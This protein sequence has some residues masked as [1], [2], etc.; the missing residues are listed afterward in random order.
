MTT[1]DPVTQLH[2]ADQ[3]AQCTHSVA[4]DRVSSGAEAVFDQALTNGLTAIVAHSW[5]G[6]E[7]N[8]GG[9]ILSAAQLL[10]VVRDNSKTATGGVVRV[11]HDPMKPD[12]GPPILSTPTPNFTEV[13]IDV[14][15]DA[16]TTTQI[17]RHAREIGSTPPKSLTDAHLTALEALDYHP[18]LGVYMSEQ[19]DQDQ[20]RT[21]RADAAE[22]DR[23]LRTLHALDETELERRRAIDHT[24]QFTYRTKDS[25]RE[26]EEC[27]VCWADSL[28]VDHRDDLLD[29]IGIG[30]CY[31]CSYERTP[32][33]ADFMAIDLQI[34]RAM[35]KDD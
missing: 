16:I 10:D 14:L 7:K 2:R 21:Q 8:S 31:I 26:V 13:A 24:A 9:R 4:R 34:E 33:V 3:Y 15:N 28:V 32:E 17:I 6:K 1:P 25:A 29:A 23:A 22:Y 19:R 12:F 18:A 11:V 5:P 20:N 30:R 27:P 35:A